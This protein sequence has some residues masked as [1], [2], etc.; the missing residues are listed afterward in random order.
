MEQ[1]TSN[2]EVFVS[3]IEIGAEA[4]GKLIKMAVENGATK[5]VQ[6]NAKKQDHDT[7]FD[8]RTCVNCGDL[9]ADQLSKKRIFCPEVRDQNNKLIKDCK[10]AYNRQKNKPEQEEQRVIV[11]EIRTMDERIEKMVAK[12]GYKVSTDDLNAYDIPLKSPLRYKLYP[13]GFLESYFLGFTIVSNPI[14]NTHKIYKND[15]Q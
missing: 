14:N 3:G 8:R 10:G 6:G 15:E 5:P 9:L 4:V 11:N 13:N 7:F 1:K 12:K 2:V